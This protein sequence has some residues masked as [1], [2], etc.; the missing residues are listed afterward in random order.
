LWAVSGKII[1]CQKYLFLADVPLTCACFRFGIRAAY[2]ENHG[3][4]KSIESLDEFTQGF[5]YPMTIFRTSSD[6]VDRDESQKGVWEFNW[7]DAEQ[8]LDNAQVY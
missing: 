1:S 5:D 8:L 4:Q 7:E 6:E 3:F 2:N